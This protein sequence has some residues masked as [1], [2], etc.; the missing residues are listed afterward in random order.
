[1]T[2]PRPPTATPGK[3]SSTTPTV[4]VAIRGVTSGSRVSPRVSV[5]VERSPHALHV[6]RSPPIVRL[7]PASRP[8][9][10]GY[11]PVSKPTIPRLWL[12]RSAEPF[13]SGPK[14]AGI[15][16]GAPHR[17][18]PSAARR[19]L[20]TA[21][22]VASWSSPPGCISHQ[23]SQKPPT[24]KATPATQPSPKDAASRRHRLLRASSPMCP[25]YRARRSRVLAPPTRRP[26]PFPRSPS[27]RHATR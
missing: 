7:A 8:P 23:S 10:T 13:G 12:L 19:H 22:T 4:K 17:R 2:A 26:G 6:N 1:M 3:R 18:R 9:S 16:V 24:T 27:E 14:S 25:A 20:R 11:P 5:A 21:R 15:S